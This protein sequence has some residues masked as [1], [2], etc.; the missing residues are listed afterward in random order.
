MAAA[1]RVAAAIRLSNDVVVLMVFSLVL[2]RPVCRV[3]GV[4]ASSDD[5]SP[6]FLKDFLTTSFT[7][8][9]LAL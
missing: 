5:D 2:S 8:S 7:E 6:T 9:E 3:H 4:G 1:V